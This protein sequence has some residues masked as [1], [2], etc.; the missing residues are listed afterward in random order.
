MVNM[1]ALTLILLSNGPTDFTP[2]Y[3]LRRHS[4][5]RQGFFPFQQIQRILNLT[6]KLFKS[7]SL[8]T[9]F[10]IFR[11]PSSAL[12]YQFPSDP[13]LIKY[14]QS[15]RRYKMAFIPGLI[16]INSFHHWA[17]LL[18]CRLVANP[19]QK[20]ECEEEMDI[21]TRH[22]HRYNQTHERGSLS[23]KKRM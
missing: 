7:I 15:A 11:F 4:P 6:L 20:E 10:F 5:L 19:S 16:A 22:L 18:I 2:M 14:G 3:H 8:T 1:S 12:I 9:T 21:M 13:E 17:K 23:T